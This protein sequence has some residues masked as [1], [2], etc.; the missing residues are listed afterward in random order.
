MPISFAQAALGAVVEVPTLEGKADLKIPPGSQHGQLFRLAGLGLPD[1]RGHKR[2]DELV[3]ILIEVPHRLNKK[4]KELLTEYA[5][6]EDKSVLP[7]SKS[8][9]DRFMDYIAGGEH[10]D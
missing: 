9:L 4:Q 7:E 1:I 10:A 8:F 6:S 5:A 3:Q 2:G